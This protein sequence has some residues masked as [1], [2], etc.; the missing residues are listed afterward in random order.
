MGGNA[1]HTPP[2]FHRLRST[3]I[4]FVGQLSARENPTCKP[5]TRPGKSLSALASGSLPPKIR[6]SP[7]LDCIRISL[8]VKSVEIGKN[9]A[10]TGRRANKLRQDQR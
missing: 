4:Q 10:V 5:P 2:I 1:A 6:F 8:P 7:Y 3:D 9:L